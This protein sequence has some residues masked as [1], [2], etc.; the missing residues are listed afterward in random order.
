MGLNVFCFHHGEITTVYFFV[1]WSQE[2]R[3]SLINSEEYLGN[4]RERKRKRLQCR[5]KGPC[6]DAHSDKRVVIQLKRVNQVSPKVRSSV[7]MRP[8]RLDSRRSVP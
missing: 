7:I 8:I 5:L 6:Y 2:H 1:G 4:S 3:K